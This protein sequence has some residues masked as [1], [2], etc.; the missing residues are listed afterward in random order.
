[1]GSCTA[2]LNSLPP[3]DAGVNYWLFLLAHLVVGV[4][5]K[6]TAK[7]EMLLCKIDCKMNV[8]NSGFS[9]K[10]RNGDG[11]DMLQDWRLRFY[12]CLRLHDRDCCSA[13]DGNS[14]CHAPTPLYF[15]EMTLCQHK[16]LHWRWPGNPNGR[17][18]LCNLLCLRY[19]N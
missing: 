17:L 16:K 13:A 4:S 1:M 8:Q 15:E 7:C 6:Q 18:K 10:L 14:S 3:R 9:T 2:H 11:G 12:V 5:K 19:R